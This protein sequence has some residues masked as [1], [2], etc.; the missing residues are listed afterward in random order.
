MQQTLYVEH[1][2]KGVQGAT[3]HLCK[4]NNLKNHSALHPR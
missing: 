2:S 3:L 4:E 1:S